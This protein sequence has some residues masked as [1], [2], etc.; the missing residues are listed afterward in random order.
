MDMAQIRNSRI[1]S[2]AVWKI[3]DIMATTRTHTA[4]ELKELLRENQIPTAGVK[5]ELLARLLEAGFME[6]DMRKNLPTKM[7]SREGEEMAVQCNYD[8]ETCERQAKKLIQRYGLCGI[9]AKAMV[10][11]K[12][13]RK[14]LQREQPTAEQRVMVNDKHSGDEETSCK[15]EAVG[16]NVYGE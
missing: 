16:I 1:I 12:L 5:Y 3:V 9:V 10:C 4:A 15:K 2:Y 14:A 6:E 8:I 11:H 7:G 13:K